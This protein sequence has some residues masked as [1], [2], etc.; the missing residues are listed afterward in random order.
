M[1]KGVNLIGYARAEFGLGE[2]CRSAARA[3]QSAGIPFCII[4][5]SHCPA[6]QNDFS[7]I[8]KEVQEPI[9]NTNIFFINSDQF[10]IHYKKNNLPK[11]W[12]LNR[13]NIG[14][15]HWELEKLPG[16]WL[17]SLRLINE[18][19]VPSSFTSNVISSRTR[20]PVITIP[21]SIFVEIPSVITRKDFNLPENKFLF[22]TMFDVSSTLGR[23]NPM[24]VI[25]AFKMAFPGKNHSVALAIK[26][27]NGSNSSQLEVL[28][29]K[30]EEYQNIIFIDKVLDRK[31]VNGLLYVS[32]SYV[33]L[34]RSE[35]FGLPLA[36]AMFLGKPVIATNWSGN[37]EFM[38]NNNSCLVDFTL[39]NI[40]QDYGPYTS[41]QRWAEP[42]LLQASQSMRKLVFDKKYADKIGLVG[43]RTIE[44]K[45]SSKAIGEKYRLRLN[46]IGQLPSKR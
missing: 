29:Q 33:S 10:F 2:A 32:D 5:F 30:C 16:T 34:H 31:T 9:F 25:D 11:K 27:N 42:D 7:W 19:W 20:K 4:N 21:H 38:N 40:G 23:K 39:K 44:T 45:L 22:F 36:E 41:N 17:K 15:W 13:Y 3:L 26:I 46:Q 24:A 37:L 28:K 35:G 14:Y 43:K 8:H 18:V 6:R 12:F 1:K